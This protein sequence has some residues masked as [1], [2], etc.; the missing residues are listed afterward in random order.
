MLTPTSLYGTVKGLFINSDRDSSLESGSVEA[1]SAT[2]DGFEG[3]AHGGATRPSCIRV[4]KQYPSKGTEI[5]NTRQISILSVEELE[6]IARRLDVPHVNPEWVGA[7]MV[8]EGLPDFTQVPPSSR[9]IFEN[10]TGLVVDIENGPCKFPAQIIESHYPGHG[11]DFPKV[12]RGLRG[13]VGWVERPGEISLG[14]TCRLHIP[15]Q[16]I[17]GHAEV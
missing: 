5:R 11:L 14:D 1:V 6:E 16:R 4:I 8:V 9:L 10:G 17:Y 7:N 3:E 15:P 13:I 12:A 2:W